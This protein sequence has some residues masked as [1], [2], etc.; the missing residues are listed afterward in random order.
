V[1]KS[2]VLAA[3]QQVRQLQPD[4]IHLHRCQKGMNDGAT[5]GVFTLYTR[6]HSGGMYV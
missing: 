2:V 5:G 4:C 6:I 3:E 1:N